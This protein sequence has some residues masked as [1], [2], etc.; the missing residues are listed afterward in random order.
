MRSNYASTTTSLDRRKLYRSKME[1]KEAKRTT[2]ARVSS[3]S[4]RIYSLSCSSP[5]S[6]GYSYLLQPITMHETSFRV[7][8]K[9]KN[10]TSFDDGATPARTSQTIVF[11]QRDSIT[12]PKFLQG[13]K[14]KSTPAPVSRPLLATSPTNE[15][16]RTYALRS[17]ATSE[18]NCSISPVVTNV[19][20]LDMN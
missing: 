9:H 5:L 4:C 2:L 8:Q 3:I 1:N 14:K 11:E 12:L 17:I 6:I 10:A 13:S 15:S 18:E 19:S 16:D 7:K 20:Y